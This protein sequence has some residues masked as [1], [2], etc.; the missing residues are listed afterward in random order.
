MSEIVRVLR[1]EE[2]EAFERFLERSYG[3]GWGAFS[4]WGPE[5]FR[6]D[7][8]SMQCHLVLE[9]DGRI[10]SSVGGYPMTLVMRPARVSLVGV[11]NVATDPSVR[12][13]G[14]MSRML[15]ASIGLWRERGWT[16]SPLWGDRQRYGSFGWASCGLKYT[17]TVTR[18]SLDRDGIQT[19]EVE[20]VDPRDPLV[21]E[22]LRGLH[23]TLA[24]R[25]ER[26]RFDLKLRREGVRVFL[27]P[28]GYLLSRG[29]Y[30][31]MRIAEIVSP[32]RREPELIAGALNCTHAGIAH[33]EFGAGERERLARVTSVMSGWQVGPQGMV[34][35]LNWPRLLSELRPLLAQRA[36]GL[37][38]FAACVGCRWREETEWATVEWDGADLAVAAERSGEGIEIDLPTL[39]GLMLGSPHPMPTEL[40]AFARLLPIPVHVPT[41]DRV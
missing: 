36:V 7:E 10:V 14:Y 32:T 30:G 15:E 38:P 9:I 5:I 3:C 1:V 34:R 20:E 13:K 18:R 40:G 28:D 11:G 31:D 6:D 2:R 33:V 25:I 35:I 27:G 4:R 37:P 17:V 29:D 12:G 26:P 22:Q 21:V 23:A 16:L 19:A 8:E 24:F 41:L 39:T